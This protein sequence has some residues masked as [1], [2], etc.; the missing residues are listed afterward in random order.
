MEQR[1]TGGAGLV[2]GV[3]S[4]VMPDAPWGFEALGGRELSGFL[5][6]KGGCSRKCCGKLAGGRLGAVGTTPAW[7]GVAWPRGCLGQIRDPRE[8]APCGMWYV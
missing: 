8:W 5:T 7:D 3:G 1:L 6:V 4:F 2:F